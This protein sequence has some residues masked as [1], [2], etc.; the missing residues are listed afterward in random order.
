MNAEWEPLFSELW[1]LGEKW[2]KAAGAN[3]CDVILRKQE[4]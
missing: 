2:S 3:R 4:A 1:T